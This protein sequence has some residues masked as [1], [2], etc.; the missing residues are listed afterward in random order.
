MENKPE[1]EQLKEQEDVK[2]ALK[3]TT[4]TKETIA[5]PAAKMQDKLWFSTYILF[6]LGLIAL[7]YLLGLDFSGPC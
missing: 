4:G 2:T 1:I 6:A 7:Y 3:Q 5:K